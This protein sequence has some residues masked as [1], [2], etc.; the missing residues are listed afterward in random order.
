M[1]RDGKLSAVFTGTRYE[2]T[3]EH[4]RERKRHFDKSLPV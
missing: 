4:Y 3:V 1:D 2:G